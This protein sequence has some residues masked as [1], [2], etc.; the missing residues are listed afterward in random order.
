MEQVR[1]FASPWQLGLPILAAAAG[2]AALYVMG[3]DQGHLLSVV[4]GSA[5]FDQNL[6]HEFVHDARHAAGFPCH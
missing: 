3:I 1:T 2:L 6:L 5:A 4:H